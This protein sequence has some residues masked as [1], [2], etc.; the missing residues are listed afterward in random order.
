AT[1]DRVY[2]E[3]M[4]E[5]AERAKAAGRLR[6]RPAIPGF[7]GSLFVRSLEP[8]N[9]RKLKAPKKIRPREAP[10][11]SDAA[12]RFHESQD[13]VRAFLREYQGIDLAGVRF[14]NP[15]VPGIR[16]SLATGLHV[17]TA[18]ERRHLQQ[19]RRVREGLVE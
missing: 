2:L 18:H 16:F 15:F 17:I 19:A 11:L 10:P 9:T 12:T 8:T 5:P 4:R 3:A 7:I 1:A 14:P 13:R 6:R